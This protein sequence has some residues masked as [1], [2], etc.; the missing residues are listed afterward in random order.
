PSRPPREPTAG[1]SLPPPESQ[2]K[3]PKAVHG[4]FVK[5]RPGPASPGTVPP[6]VQRPSRG[7]CFRGSGTF[8]AP[9]SSLWHAGT[10]AVARSRVRLPDTSPCHLLT[11]NPLMKRAAK[12]ANRHVEVPRRVSYRP[13]VETLEDR[14]HP[15][16]ILLGRGLLAAWLGQNINMLGT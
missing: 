9:S 13:T 11:R 8:C 2:L 5:S 1:Q 16:D 15:G 12:S 4:L 14:L 6:W 7:R 10:R 3:N